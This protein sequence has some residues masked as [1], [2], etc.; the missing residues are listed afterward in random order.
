MV[1]FLLEVGKWGYDKHG[2]PY[3]NAARDSILSGSGDVTGARKCEVSERS[4]ER[5]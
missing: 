5:V 1:K 2:D 4:S 3:R